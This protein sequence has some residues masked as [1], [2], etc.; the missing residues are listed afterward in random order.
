[1]A[2]FFDYDEAHSK[3]KRILLKNTISALIPR[4]LHKPEALLSNQPDQDHMYALTYLDAFSGPGSYGNPGVD[5]LFSY[6]TDDVCNLGTPLIAIYVAIEQMAKLNESVLPLRFIFNDADES[7][8][9]L[10]IQLVSYV[11][12]LSGWEEQEDFP[13]EVWRYVKAVKYSA[14]FN[15][16]CQS[17]LIIYTNYK[18]EQMTFLADIPPPMLSVI[19]PFGIAQIPMESIRWLIGEEKDFF[20]NLMV[21]PLHWYG[22]N[23]VHFK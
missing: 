14:T 5:R 19:D 1:M 8:I 20:I 16:K 12:R 9:G 21:A 3:A 23:I 22:C 2:N 13:E 17:I 11:L 7:H 4:R 15:S 6:F 10:L 18:F